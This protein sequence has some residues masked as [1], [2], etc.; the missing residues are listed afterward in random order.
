MQNDTFRPFQNLFF[1]FAF[2][3]KFTNVMDAFGIDDPVA[4]VTV[5][6]TTPDVIDWAEANVTKLNAV[7]TN[8]TN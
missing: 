1:A 6:V 7:R 5:P 3:F 2:V 8:T 4:S